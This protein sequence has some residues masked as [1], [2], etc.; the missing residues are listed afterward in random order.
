MLLVLRKALQVRHLVLTRLLLVKLVRPRA[1]MR[2]RQVPQRLPRMLMTLLAQLPPPQVH[3]RKL[4]IQALQ[5][6]QLVKLPVLQLSQVQPKQLLQ[7]LLVLHSQLLKPPQA[8]RQ[9]LQV[10]LQRHQPQMKRHLLP[11]LQH[12]ERLPYNQRLIRKLR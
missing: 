7:V 9:L 8:L 12:Q 4:E 3:M 2:L 10:Q 6:Q 1:L 5:V 11:L